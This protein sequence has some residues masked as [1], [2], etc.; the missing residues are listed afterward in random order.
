M[1]DIPNVDTEIQPD[2]VKTDYTEEELLA[3]NLTDLRKIAKTIGVT[4]VSGFTK[5]ELIFAI[6]AQQNQQ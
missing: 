1:N 3:K 2:E 4:A 5:S 6:R